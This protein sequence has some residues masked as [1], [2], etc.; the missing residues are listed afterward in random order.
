MKNTIK[1]NLLISIVLMMV[2]LTPACDDYF[3]NPLKDKDTGE[4][5]NLLILDFNFFKTRMAYKIAD[6][7]T[8]EIINT[9]AIIKFTGK[10]ANDIVTYA[11]EKNQEYQTSVGQ[12]ELTTDPNIAISENSP[13]EFTINVEINGYS[14]FSKAISIQSEGIKTYE[15]E[16]SKLSDQSETE[17]TGD[18]DFG[19]DTVFHFIVSPFKSAMVSETPYKIGY[20]ITLSNLLKFT[21]ESNQLLFKNKGEAL[22]AYKNDPEN[23][24]KITIS[25]FNDYQPGIEFVEIDGKKRNALFHKLETGN[26]SSLMIAGKKVGSLNGGTITSE[27]TNPS[28]F[29]PKILTFVNFEN[30]SWKMT[31][32]IIN[33]N[34]LNFGYTLA[35]VSKEELCAKGS[36]IT[37]K[38]NVIS[39]FAIAADVFDQE[40]KL[41][42][43]ISFKGKF[44][45]TFVI[46]NVPAKAV[47]LVFREN[48]PS[49]KAIQPLQIGNFCGGN[50]EVLVEPATGYQQYQVVLKA[51]CRDNKEVAIA[52]TYNAEVKLKN[53]AIWQGINMI[54]GVVDVLGKPNEDY[55]LRLLWKSEWEYSSYSTR[56]DANG[57]YL[58]VPVKDA[59]VQSKKLNDGRIQIGVEQ[60][61]DQNICDDLGW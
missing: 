46:E 61:F 4:D 43:T 3:V 27:C 1:I 22:N 16:L 53:S 28:D 29:L 47:K 20:T 56:F 8:G 31:G 32:T 57:N 48:N 59:K 25:S 42:T 10:N 54:G 45:E 50:Y 30:N 6:A 51:M 24:I 41:V 12:L 13:F 58:G 40:N 15:L 55:E 39:S 19:V 44:P 36:S 60:I 26:L 21:D 34:T 38:S 49:F 33:H 5:I 18:I 11:G 37:F 17:L 9:E 23:F 35:T 2:I 7:K 52:P 14:P